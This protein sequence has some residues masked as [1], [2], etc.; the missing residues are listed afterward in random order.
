MKNAKNP[1]PPTNVSQVF[2]TWPPPVRKKL[3]LV[4]QL[5]FS[6][7]AI[8]GVGPITET[9]KWGQPAYLTEISKSGTTIRL[10]SNADTGSYAVYFHC[11]TTLL[12]SFREMYSDV[13]RY[14]GNRA[15]VFDISDHI[16]ENELM[17]C[18]T[19]ALCYHR[20]KVAR[21]STRYQ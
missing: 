9:L 12:A 8:E 5:I 4:R 17:V 18:L 3:M 20:D 7:A 2:D 13:F 15:I 16:P 14:E 1:P 19:M 10:G 11:Q 6:A 21:S